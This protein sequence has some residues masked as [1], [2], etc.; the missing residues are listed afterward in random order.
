MTTREYL[1]QVRDY[2]RKIENKISEE[3]QL[4]MLATSLSS[5]SMGEKVQTS[6][7][8]DHVGDTIVKIA[9]LQQEIA[10]DISEMSD[11]QQE[12]SS[13]INSLDNSLYSQLLHKKY[14]EYKSLVTVADEMGYSI[15]H[16]RSCHLKA[17][18]AV[19]KAKG[20]KR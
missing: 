18:E 17:I 7:A 13:T 1:E 3:Y 16:I 2:K 4:R 19:R 20:F 6:G 9:D 5:F 11:I 14:V 8:K 15:Q 10:K 12:V